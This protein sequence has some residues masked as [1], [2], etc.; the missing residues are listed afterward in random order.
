MTS[1]LIQS[2]RVFSIVCL[3]TSLTAIAFAD[4]RAD[5][6]KANAEAQA[7]FEAEKIAAEKLSMETYKTEISTILTKKCGAC[8][9]P[10]KQEGDLSFE[11]LDPDMLKGNAAARW[12][13]VLTKVMDLEMPPEDATQLTDDEM[14]K[15]VNWVKKEMKRSGRHLAM[16]R[17]YHNGNKVP[18]RLLFD[19][20]HQA[21]FDV[22]ARVRRLSPAIYDAFRKEA[23]KGFENLVTQPFSEDNNTTF[24]DMGAPKIDEPVSALLLRNALVI[25]ERQTGHTFEDGKFKQMIGSKKEYLPLVNPEVEL[26]D[27]LMKEGITREFRNVLERD[28]T[29]EEL[30]KY[31]A[32]MKKNV[33]D[34]GRVTGV[35]YALA[36]VFLTPE[37]VFRFEVGNGEID[38]QGRKRLSPK[39]IADAITYA[40]GDRR[41][42]SWVIDA[43][44]K[45]KLDTKEGVA[46]VV[47][48]M[49]KDPKFAKPRIMRFFRE[50]FQYEAAISVAKDSK[51]FKHHDARVLV[52]DTDKLIEY[53]LEKDENVLYELLTTNKSFVG[54]AKAE[55]T[56]KKRA[57][58]LK[59]FNADKKKNPEKF[60][61]KVHKPWGKDLYASYNLEDFPKT[62]P[63]E[64]PKD[65]RAGILTQPRLARCP[66][67]VG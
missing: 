55:E 63:T 21:D 65:Q 38:K 46:E 6:E 41:P 39:E 48:R 23:G 67:S 62:Q 66:F 28:P 51:Q 31:I 30:A 14:V 61:N 11:T 3:C 18:H 40:L 29:E 10:K 15:L 47:D 1:P 33:A 8:H 44:V 45:G 64:L 9:G 25:T 16:R 43:A 56:I 4:K 7:K 37:A 59:K 13:V 2:L 5:A 60:K 27:Q 20:K 34:A 22:P 35:R 52:S 17:E 54:A 26:T 42:E 36:A 12:A 58:G 53:F 32:F 49:L 24:Q 50:F 57:D 19:D